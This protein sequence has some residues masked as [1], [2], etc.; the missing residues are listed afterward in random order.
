MTEK[1]QSA[2]GIPTT[3]KSEN[4]T[5]NNSIDVVT[6]EHAATQIPK[7]AVSTIPDADNAGQL[8]IED[9]LIAVSRIAD[10]RTAADAKI[11]VERALAI[12]TTYVLTGYLKTHSEIIRAIERRL[13]AATPA[14]CEKYSVLKLNGEHI[15]ALGRVLGAYGDD[16]IIL[17][18]TGSIS[19]PFIVETVTDSHTPLAVADWDKTAP[20]TRRKFIAEVTA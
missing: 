5:G 13:P 12:G 20:K 8:A 7:N 4:T 3:A 18:A 14:Q 19:A 16:V 10:C 1:K 6:Q 11:F 2:R 15:P 9:L 17:I